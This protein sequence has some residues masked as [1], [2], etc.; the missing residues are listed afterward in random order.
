MFK[1]AEKTVKKV[2]KS[3]KKTV[4]LSEPVCEQMPVE[5]VEQMVVSQPVFEYIEMS[6]DE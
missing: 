2:R 1:K 6:I 4:V 3:T 5:K